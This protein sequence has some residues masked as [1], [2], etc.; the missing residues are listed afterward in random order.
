MRAGFL[1]GELECVSKVADLDVSLLTDED[2]VAF[3][4][5]VD[6][7]PAMDGPQ[8]LEYFPDDVGDDSFVDAF[9]VALDELV[10]R[11]PLHILDEHE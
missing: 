11:A 2:V 8:A 3:E 7:P 9:P 10:E 6:L 4:I 5:A 1:F